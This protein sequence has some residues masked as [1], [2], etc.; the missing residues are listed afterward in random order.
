MKLVHWSLAAS[1]LCAAGCGA[2]DRN[3][4]VTFD[5]NT[6]DVGG[7]G[8]DDAGAASGGDRAGGSGGSGGTASGGT[9]RDDGVCSAYVV[10]AEQTTPD[11]LIV[12]DRSGS[13]DTTGNPAT[14]RWLGS[15]DALVQVTSQFDDQIRF[16]LMTF[17]GVAADPCAGITNPIDLI[18]CQLTNAGAGACEVGGLD[19]PVSLNAA[20]TINGV[21]GPM[22]ANGSTPTAPTLDAARGVI[23][24]GF[25]GPDQKVVPKYVLLVT[26]GAPNCGA[27]GFDADALDDTLTAIQALT[28]DGVKTYV[29]GFQTAG[30]DFEGQLDQMAALGNTGE[31]RHRSVSSGADLETTFTELA[32]KAV[33]CSFVLEEPAKNASYVQVRVDD[34][35]VNLDDPN[36]WVLSDDGLTVTVQGAACDALQDGGEHKLDVEVLCDVV[37][38]I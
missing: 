30:T 32:G 15:R 31:T 18:T 22:N 7:S 13:M 11:I 24:S 27:G 1:L 23:G 10:R 36:G 37:P 14:D 21:L 16:G 4:G 29:V 34:Q 20:A 9:G 6:D 17:P 3:G 33:S 8:G 19:V 26:D 28:D 2:S 25:V 12:L 38:I 5:T 35:Q